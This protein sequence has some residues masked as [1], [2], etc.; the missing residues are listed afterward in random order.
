[1]MTAFRFEW[2]RDYLKR[3]PK[4][5]ID[6]GAYNGSDAIAFKE[7]WPDCRVIAFEACPDNYAA[8]QQKVRVRLAGVECHHFAV[9]DEDKS[10][11]FFSNFDTL[12]DGYFGQSGSILVPK[13]TLVAKWPSISFKTVRVVAGIRLDTFCRMHGI[14]HIDVLHMDVQ[15]AEYRALLG[16]GE[17]RPPMIYLEI[18]ETAEVG[19]YEGATPDGLLRGW[20]DKNGYRRAWESEHDALYVHELD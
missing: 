17:M 5:L 8:I 2:V 4:V 6:A 20:F 7:E 19:R 3:D 13:L 11:A 16:L 1:M 9:M 12:Q 18:D 14:D 10:I 15:G